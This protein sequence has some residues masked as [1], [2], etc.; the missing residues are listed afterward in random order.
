MLGLLVAAPITAAVVDVVTFNAHTAF[1]HPM[2]NAF[3]A[4]GRILRYLN[5]D[6]YA[7][8]ELPAAFNRIETVR[9]FRDHYLTNFYIVRSGNHDNANRQCIFSRYP[10]ID[11][12]DVVTNTW[13]PTGTYLHD[14]TNKFTRELFWAAIALTNAA[15][16]NVY[17]AHLK[18]TAR[19][20]TDQIYDPL[21]RESEA[22]AIR[23]YLALQWSNAPARVTLLCGDMNTDIDEAS[24]GQAVQILSDGAAGV[25]LTATPVNAATGRKST[26]YEAYFTNR[27]DYQ[28]PGRLLTNMLQ[29]VF[30]SDHGVVPPGLNWYD[31]IQASDH[32]PVFYRYYLPDAAVAR[33]HQMLITE[34][35]VWRKT[36]KSNEFIELYN[37][38]SAAENLRDWRVSDLD[39]AGTVIAIQD[40]VIA[41]GAYALIRIGNPAW[42]ETTSTGDNVL[43]LYVDAA[44]LNFDGT[45]DQCVLLNERG[46]FVDAVLWNNNGTQS[47]L[48]DD[49]NQLSEYMWRY[50]TVSNATD[51]N[52]HTLRTPGTQTAAGRVLYRYFA[53]DRNAYVDTDRTNDWRLDS[54]GIGTP[55]SVNPDFPEPIMG[56]AMFVV[57]TRVRRG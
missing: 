48:A 9:L 30:R 34:L 56:I 24:H 14:Y 27:L 23:N 16:L 49:F 43:A 7:V 15:V 37:A 53:P 26:Y 40:A 12:D 33:E 5:A 42:S 19:S 2:S 28:L 54:T 39:G 55:G 20:G 1:D 3:H 45:A 32:Y 50:A 52:A 47:T 4:A 25:R 46:H 6:I 44:E 21:R 38:G 35:N 18:A 36:D 11:F 22:R 10:I 31:S 51:Y 17:S 57:M 13:V 29:Y 41:P 8:Q